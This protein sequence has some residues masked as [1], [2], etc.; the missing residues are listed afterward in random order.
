MGEENVYQLDAF[1][2]AS[3]LGVGRTKA[4]LHLLA[5]V[6][7]RIFMIQSAQKASRFVVN[8]DCNWPGDLILA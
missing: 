3:D 5:T 1:R 7:A 2:P 6:Q 8:P 4:L